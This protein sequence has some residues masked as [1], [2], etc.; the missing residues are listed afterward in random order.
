MHD[1]VSG[2]SREAPRG[3]PHLGVDQSRGPDPR[4]RFSFSL[5]H[6]YPKQCFSVLYILKDGVREKGTS[7]FISFLRNVTNVLLHKGQDVIFFQSISVSYFSELT[8]NQHSLDQPECNFR[9]RAC[10]S[11][12]LWNQNCCHTI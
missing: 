1:N 11:R 8:I 4:E 10:S 9:C 7:L 3:C 6:L 2:G 12:P 5:K